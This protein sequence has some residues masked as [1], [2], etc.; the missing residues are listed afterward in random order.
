M[1]SKETRSDEKVCIKM[2]K[3]GVVSNFCEEK[4][5]LIS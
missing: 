5:F 3:V 1:E 4:R 2:F